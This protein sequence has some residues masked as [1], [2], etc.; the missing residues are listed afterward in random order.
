MGKL[1]S[2][3]ESRNA[4]VSV[5]T[6]LVSFFTV[7]GIEIETSPNQIIDLFTNQ[8]FQGVL[9]ILI[10]NFLAPLS[11]LIAKYMKKELSW[12]LWIQSDNFK[13]QVISLVAIILSAYFNETIVGILVTMIVQIA[14]FIIHLLE[15]EKSK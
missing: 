8:N 1:L 6:I 3:L 4:L 9:A 12:K 14:N 2:V 13:A 5:L 11:K 7:N 15:N 10:A